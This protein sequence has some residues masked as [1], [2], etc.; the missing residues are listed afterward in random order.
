M[1]VNTQRGVLISTDEQSVV[2]LIWYNEQVPDSRRFLLS[3]LDARHVF[4]RSDRLALVHG[5]LERRLKSVVWDEDAAAIAAAA[6]AA[7]AAAP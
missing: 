3:R 1:S 5:A 6:E 2:F 7:K 4:V